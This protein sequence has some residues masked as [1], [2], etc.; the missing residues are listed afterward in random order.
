LLKTDKLQDDRGGLADY[1]RAI[2]LDPNNALAYG[3]RGLLK[4]NRL[5]DRSGGITDIQQ[6]AK[7]FQQQGDTS[8]YREAIENLKK[9][10]KNGNGLAR[11]VS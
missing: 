4:H 11:L 7:L 3:N 6:A 8:S 5:N 2:Q 9:W 1:N 10:Q